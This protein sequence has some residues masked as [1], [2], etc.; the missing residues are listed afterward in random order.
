M[1]VT[2]GFMG[3]K[4]EFCLLQALAILKYSPTIDMY[5][6]FQGILLDF[7]GILAILKAVNFANR[8]ILHLER[9]YFHEFLSSKYFTRTNFRG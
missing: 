3:F 4:K 7:S 9:F 8:K 6:I 5:I 1:C 2:N